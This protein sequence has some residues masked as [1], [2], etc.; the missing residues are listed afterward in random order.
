MGQTSIGSKCAG[1][2]CCV[3]VGA[4]WCVYVVLVITALGAGRVFE[5]VD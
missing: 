4:V 5:R 2:V 1:T 3:V